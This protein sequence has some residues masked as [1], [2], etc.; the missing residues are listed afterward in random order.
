MTQTEDILSSILRL[1]ITTFPTLYTIGIK[2]G[3]CFR[4]IEFWIL[5]L[6]S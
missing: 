3:C 6:R 1:C 5:L 4:T 2:L